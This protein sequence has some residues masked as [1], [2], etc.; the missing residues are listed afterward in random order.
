[1]SDVQKTLFDRAIKKIV[2]IDGD[3]KSLAVTQV[4]NN[5]LKSIEESRRLLKECRQQFKQ[6]RTGQ[7]LLDE[8]GAWD[9]QHQ[10]DELVID[11]DSQHAVLDTINDI[12]SQ[13]QKSDVSA[14]ESIVQ[15]IRD[16]VDADS[17]SELNKKMP[18]V[19]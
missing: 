2:K 7:R 4:L 5:E 18:D 3:T 14:Y 10:H 13:R 8:A 11:G 9:F 6:I 16:R 17:L 15:E 19:L 12:T 1:M